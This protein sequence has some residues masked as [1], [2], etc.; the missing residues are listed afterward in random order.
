MTTK[1]LKTSDILGEKTHS[2][3]YSGWCRQRIV[4]LKSSTLTESEAANSCLCSGINI[5]FIGICYKLLKSAWPLP[6]IAYTCYT[7]LNMVSFFWPHNNLQDKVLTRN[8]MDT[9]HI[10]TTWTIKW[11]RWYKNNKKSQLIPFR[12]A[13]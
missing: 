1:P 4:N 8:D 6:R 9:Y 13:I 11:R 5:S 3:L 12:L 2:Q 7:V 10:V